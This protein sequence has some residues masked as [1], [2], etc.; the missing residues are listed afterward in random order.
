MNIKRSLSLILIV[1]VFSFSGCLKKEDFEFD[2]VAESTWDPDLAAALVN[3]NLTIKDIIGIADSGLFTTDPNH[4]VTLVYRN[5]LYTVTLPEVVPLPDQSF[6][7]TVQL[8]AND[9]TTLRSASVNKT[10]NDVLP[11][12]IPN[13]SYLTS[14][15]LQSAYLKIQ[16]QSFIPLSGTINISIP[17]LP[18]PSTK[19]KSILAKPTVYHFRRNS[20]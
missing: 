17:A 5:D 12:T 15:A 14:I 11:F 2:K 19:W 4:F 3:S 6:D 18:G 1:L 13:N 16:L 9:S 7:H 8:D 10:I 20:N